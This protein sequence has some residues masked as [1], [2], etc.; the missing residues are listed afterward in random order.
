MVQK[1]GI[2]RR[3]TTM[4]FLVLTNDPFAFESH[5]VLETFPSI[6]R[7]DKGGSGDHSSLDPN[8]NYRHHHCPF[9]HLICGEVDLMIR[10]MSV[11]LLVAEE[12]AW[13]FWK[14]VDTLQGVP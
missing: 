6:V 7:I 8:M 1:V 13:P 10:M 9:L 5:R 11:A 2:R 14:G 3:Y 4:L 12:F